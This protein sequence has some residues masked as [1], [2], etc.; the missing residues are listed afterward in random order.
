MERRKNCV[1]VDV[2][3]Q[4][5]FAAGHIPGAVCVPN[6]D[7]QE[8]ETGPLSDKGQTLLNILPHSRR[9]KEAA[10]KLADMGYTDVYEIRRDSRLDRRHHDRLIKTKERKRL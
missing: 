4:D 1:V 7:I 10:Q 8:G 2:R 5:E 3:R 9:S 6:E